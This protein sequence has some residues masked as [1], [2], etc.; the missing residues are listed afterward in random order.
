MRKSSRETAQVRTD[1]G[2]PAGGYRERHP[3][4]SSGSK[5]VRESLACGEPRLKQ[6]GFPFGG[7]D[8]D[9]FCRIP[10][11]LQ[12]TEV[13]VAQDVS[14]LCFDLKQWLAPTGSKQ[15]YDCQ[16]LFEICEV[17]T[18]NAGSYGE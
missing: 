1:P 8:S 6:C 11:A 16:S 15:N 12:P 5:L 2:H 17:R 7:A 18:R 9:Q 13:P 10:S 4:D 3:T 14:V